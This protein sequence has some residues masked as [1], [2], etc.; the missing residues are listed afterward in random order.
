MAH[1]IVAVGRQA[2]FNDVISFQANV[3][4]ERLP[5]LG[6]SIEHHDTVVAGAQSQFIFGTNH[7]Q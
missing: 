2:N 1:R 4:G 5:H 3:G 7:P 6:S